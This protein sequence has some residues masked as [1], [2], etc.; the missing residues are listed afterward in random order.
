MVGEGRTGARQR[1]WPRRTRR[2]G[3]PRTGPAARQSPS[4]PRPSALRGGR[5]PAPTF[6]EL[7]SATSE[8]VNSC[9]MAA[10]RQLCSR[11]AAWWL[12]ESRRLRSVGKQRLKSSG[13]PCRAPNLDK[14][15]RTTLPALAATLI[16]CR[17][18]PRAVCGSAERV[19]QPITCHREPRVRTEAP[20]RG[21]GGM[22]AADRCREAAAACP[23]ASALGSKCAGCCSLR[24]VPPLHRWR[25]ARRSVLCHLR[26]L[27]GQTSACRWAML[28]LLH[29]TPNGRPGDAASQHMHAPCHSGRDL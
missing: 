7:C 12:R 22:A 8:Y 19:G 16:G 26:G 23:T 5:P 10:E 14:I 6:F 15:F 21:A 9:D 20:A 18:S 4:C 3:S 28:Q 17:G 25:A 13:R 1:T 2:R 24:C 11:W 27:G 29:S